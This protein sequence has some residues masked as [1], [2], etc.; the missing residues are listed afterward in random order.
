MKRGTH[1]LFWI[2]F[3]AMWMNFSSGCKSHSNSELTHGENIDTL[4]VLTLYGPTSY[5]LY[6]GE[7]MGI[8]FENIRK[9]ANEEGMT[10]E[11]TT[12]YTVSDLIDSLKTGR[13]HMAAYPVPFI[14]EFNEEVLHCG[15]TEISNQVLVQKTGKDKITDVT[16]LV[17][18]DIYVEKNSKFEY[19]LE[20]LNEEL[21]GGINIMSID[22]DTIVSEDFLQMIHEGK[23]DYA[24]IDSQIASLY[25]KH[26]PDL[27]TSL[28]L[29]TDQKASWAVALGLDSLAMKLDRW[30][31]QFHTS[32]FLRNIYKDY[33]D[34]SLMEGVDYNLKY[35]KSLNIEKGNPVSKYD[36]IFKKQA[37]V[38][39]MD[40]QLLAAIGYCESNFN[41]TAA[42][43]FGA[44]GLMQVMPSSAAAMGVDPGSLSSPDANVRA[45][46][47]ILK[48]LN[49][50]LVNKVIDPQERLKF[51]VASYN[52]G[53]GHI[54]DAMAIA[55]K[56]G[57]DPQKW[58]GN[59]SVA[60]LMKARPE[61]YNAPEVK[62]G[63]FRG[64]ETVDFVDN[65]TGIY[66]YL[67]KATP[68]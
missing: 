32:D 15:P 14:A 53:L 47:L 67:K 45:A 58:H 17:G 28:R 9:F 20:N 60:A 48:M 36:A 11:M 37:P 54:Y 40:W 19:R 62:H 27:D 10:L 65:V 44:Y 7:E 3:L 33:Y 63:Y 35:F 24:V 42:S 8:D 49:N 16:Q 50:S 12:V 46:A 55:Q 30:E 21:G 51:V 43:R 39:D 18:K 68:Q 4:K 61:Y 38:A 29:S 34:R 22:N 31:N 41:P 26:Y 1:I 66:S 5:F 6:R 23:I 57:L 64:R 13:F 52:S 56:V 25:Q 2:L 59:V